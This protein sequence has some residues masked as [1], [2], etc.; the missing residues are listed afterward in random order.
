MARPMGSAEELERRRRRIVALV[1][2]GESP[3]AVARLFGVHVTSVHRWRRMANAPGGLA[4]IAQAGPTPRLDDGQLRR[5]EAL[6]T[7]G[8]RRHGWPNDLRSEEHT[9]ELQSLR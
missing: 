5:L 8:A 4:P 3:T 2:Q 6:L 1:E 7:Q 9:S